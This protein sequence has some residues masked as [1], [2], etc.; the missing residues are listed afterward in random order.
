MHTPPLWGCF[1]GRTKDFGNSLNRANPVIVDVASGIPCGV[2][3]K[4]GNDVDAV[5]IV[6]LREPTA[7]VLRDV[8]YPGLP[9]TQARLWIGL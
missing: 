1:Q 9:S 7:A 2:V 3:A 6:F 8:A 4:D 5:G